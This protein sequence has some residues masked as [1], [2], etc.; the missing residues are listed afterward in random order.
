MLFRKAKATDLPGI[1][2]IIDYAVERMLSEGKQ[3]WDETYPTAIHIIHDI[4]HGRGYVIETEGKIAAYGAVC[5]D[6]EPAYMHIDGEWRTDSEQYVVVHR[7]AVAQNYRERGFGKKYL[8]CVEYLAAEKGS[9]SFR[10]DTNHD[11]STMLRL[12]ENSGFEYC[13]I[14]KYESGERMAFEK[15]I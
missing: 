5:F 14:I 7:L 1:M 3:Q 12:L 11:N 8:K 15:L 6:G 9:G 13:G 4:N 2:K 10:I